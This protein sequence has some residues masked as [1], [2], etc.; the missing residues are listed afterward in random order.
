MQVPDKK[1]D[2]ITCFSIE[3]TGQVSFG[4]ETQDLGARPTV[5]MTSLGGRRARANDAAHGRIGG[6]VKAKRVGTV[7]MRSIRAEDAGRS[8]SIRYTSAGI[9]RNVGSEI[10]DVTSIDEVIV[11]I[12]SENSKIREAAPFRKTEA[13]EQPD[14]CVI[15]RQQDRYDRVKIE[16]GCSR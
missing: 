14:A 3:V 16:P 8:T 2:H 5:L 4:Q 13:E 7:P 11:A 10:S 6:E 12:L 15:A 9:I 1:R